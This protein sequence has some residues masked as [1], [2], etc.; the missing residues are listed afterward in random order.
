MANFKIQKTR[1]ARLERARITGC[2]PTINRIGRHH[3]STKPATTTTATASQ[4][5]QRTTRITTV[6]RGIN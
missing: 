1:E 2:L 6:P 4:L 5:T 3:S